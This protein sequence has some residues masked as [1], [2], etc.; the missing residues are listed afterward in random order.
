MNK[1][2]KTTSFSRA[3]FHAKDYG[4]LAPG[5]YYYKIYAYDRFDNIVSSEEIITSLVTNNSLNGSV[6]LQWDAVLGTV[7]YEVYGRTQKY[8][9]KWETTKTI[10]TDSGDEFVDQSDSTNFLPTFLDV[11]TGSTGLP[12][13]SSHPYVLF[14][15]FTT[16]SGQHFIS[17]FLYKFNEFY[18]YYEGWLFYPELF[19]NFAEIKTTADGAYYSASIPSIYLN[20][21]YNKEQKKT[22]INLK[23]YQSLTG[24]VFYITIPELLISNAELEIPLNNDENSI[25]WFSIYK[26]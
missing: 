10:L 18:N 25:N 1:K 2:T 9:R 6:V 17:P 26:S 24:W 7:K 23:S 15:E 11:P 12:N 19:I 14:P 3:Y 8:D 16:D 5:I 21:I 4:F 22:T 20:L 13:F